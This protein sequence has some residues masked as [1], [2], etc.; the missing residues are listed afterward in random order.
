MNIS[1]SVTE[2]D[3]KLLFLI[4]IALI[5]FMPYWFII[6]PALANGSE[7]KAELA[8]ARQEKEQMEM[9]LVR[10]YEYLS[11]FETNSKK[12]Q[13]AT[14]KFAPYME[15]NQID[16][17]VTDLVLSSGMSI[18]NLQ[19]SR[20]N[21]LVGIEPYKNSQMAQEMAGEDGSGEENTTNPVVYS[22]LVTISVEGTMDSMY[23]FMNN[24]TSLA[25][26]IVPNSYNPSIDNNGNVSLTTT[27]TVYM[28][29]KI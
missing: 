9:G 8:N 13:E 11:N 18:K 28:V 4:L 17:M 23:N 21:E 25:P 15:N 3:K 16:K 29:D 1:T 6:K 5:V 24:V 14:E 10:Y 20:G 2:R 12:Y 27:L 7:L 22:C 26:A 19:I